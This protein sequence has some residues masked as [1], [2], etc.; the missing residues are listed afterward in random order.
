[1]QG[2]LDISTDKKAFPSSYWP[3]SALSV[4]PKLSSGWI[5][6]ISFIGRIV[7]LPLPEEVTFRTGKCVKAQPPSV[8]AVVEAVIPSLLGKQHLS[9]GL[10]HSSPLVQ[11]LTALTLARALQKFVTTREFLS[12]LSVQAAAQEGLQQ[13]QD[14]L[15]ESWSQLLATSTWKR[16]SDFQTSPSLSPLLKNRPRRKLSK[17]PSRKRTTPLKPGQSC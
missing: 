15:N 4:D 3:N 10:Q 14:L 16:G 12:G 2:G 5:S 6:T 17:H 13:D 11:H 1:M 7:S 9:K 8:Q